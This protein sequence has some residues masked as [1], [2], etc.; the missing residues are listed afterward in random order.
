MKLTLLKTTLVLTFMVSGVTLLSGFKGCASGAPEE[1]S[2]CET[3]ADC[4]ELPSPLC[5]GQWSCL[6]GQCSFD[7]TAKPEPEPKPEVCGW[8][9]E[10]AENEYCNMDVCVG[11]GA[12]P[13][14]APC[15][16]MCF[17]ICQPKDP[18]PL[19]DCTD[20]LECGADQFCDYVECE[21]FGCNCPPG[22]DCACLAV[23]P[24]CWGVCKD[25][26]T[27]KNGECGSDAD[28]G[29]NQSCSPSA[30][31]PCPPDALCSPCPE[32]GYCVDNPT[33]SCAAMLCE[34][35]THCEEYCTGVACICADGDDCDCPD[36]EGQCFAECVPDNKPPACALVDCAAGYHCEE[37]CG[38][39]TCECFDDGP[40]MCDGSEEECWGQ[41]VPDWEPPTCAAVDCGPGYECQEICEDIMCDC[42][43][44]EGAPCW[45][46]EETCYA[47][48]VP[49][50]KPEPGCWSDSD[51]GDGFQCEEAYCLFWCPEGD[52]DCCSPGYCVPQEPK[53]ECVTSGCSGEICAPEAVDSICVWQAWYVCLELTQCEQQANDGCGWT[54]SPELEDCL[55]Q[56]IGWDGQTPDPNAAE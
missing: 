36:V 29:P 41:C 46:P 7:C 44:E 30:C 17:G 2:M 15:A 8:D 49:A 9:G 42:G 12:C 25:I 4:D 24:Q 32:F 47:E 38:M 20:D 35:G 53:N 22:A 1:P 14:D 23:A 33:N 55:A 39:S 43:D 56:F 16:A 5:V 28:C 3:A 31:P 34:P 26:P 10:C 13:P 54:P 50:Q 19:P 37:I 40:C 48:C 27:K 11:G 21:D 51:C 6:E 52:D 45:C 18:K